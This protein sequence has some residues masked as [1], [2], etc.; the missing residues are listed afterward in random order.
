MGADRWPARGLQVRHVA[1]EPRLP[2]GRVC[3]RGLLRSRN[4][5]YDPATGP[6]TQEDPIGLAGGLNLY[7]FAGGDPVNFSDPFGLCPDNLKDKGGKC[8]GGLSDAQWDRVE[9]AA[10]S[11]LKPGAR[12]RVL[13]MLNSG[14]IHAAPF[15]RGGNAGEVPYSDPDAMY[16][17]VG[18]KVFRY[19]NP[20]LAFLLAHESDH[21]S[22]FGK[23]TWSAQFVDSFKYQLNSAFHAA[24]ESRADAYA[25]A[26]TIG[27]EASG[28]RSDCR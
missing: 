7:G 28:Y 4:R 12:D 25:C 26:N 14:M 5:Y 22:R 20:S 19:D 27:V 1:V 23:M 8:P 24:V 3:R 13:F 6:F 18:A 16:L 10:K 21:W 9:G 2:R 17:S 11:N 15:L